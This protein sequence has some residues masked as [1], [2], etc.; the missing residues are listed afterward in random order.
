MEPFTT[1][2]GPA[3]PLLL[4]NIDTD[5]IIRVERMTSVNPTELAPFAFETLRYD[6]T[7]TPRPDFVLN[8]PAFRDAPIL[9][10]GPNF[11]CGSS[12]EP[13]VWAVMGLGIRCVIA[14]SFGD[15]FRSNCFT[16]GVLPVILSEPDVV[17]LA[18][19]ATEGREVSVDL[20][21]QRVSSGGDTWHFEISRYRK[22]S[23]L[24][25]LDDFQ[26]A[27]TYADSLERWA[28]HDRRLRPWSWQRPSEVRR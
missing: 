8:R 17:G 24:G 4:P 7:G 18:G 2:T 26:L 15:I 14:P 23:L 11:G 22:T 13:A 21:V 6:D 28:E 10:A 9:V 27:L 19:L 16:N 20:G 12:R 5:V 1:V 3:A 25:G